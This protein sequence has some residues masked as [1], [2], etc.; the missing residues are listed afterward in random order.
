MADK[1]GSAAFDFDALGELD[2]DDLAPAEALVKKSAIVP[3]P[4]NIVAIAQKVLDSQTR[5]VRTFRGNLDM[6][7]AFA[8][9][10][11]NAGEHTSPKSSVTVVQDGVVVRYS[12]GQRRGRKPGESNGDS[13]AA[14]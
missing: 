4:A 11:R 13:A 1:K 12:A 9:A 14:K 2:F 10:L 6:A 5:E 3:V 8:Q 7:T